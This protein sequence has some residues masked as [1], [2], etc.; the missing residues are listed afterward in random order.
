M[1]EKISGSKALRGEIFNAGSNNPINIKSLIMKIFE[2][3][4]SKKSYHYFRKN[5]TFPKSEPL[6]EILFQQMDFQKV[7]KNFGWK[8]ATHID[9]GLELSIDWYRK[10]LKNVKLT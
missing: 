10:F 2:L 5:V 7:R 1:A 6:G 3:V 8:P 9:K 4:M